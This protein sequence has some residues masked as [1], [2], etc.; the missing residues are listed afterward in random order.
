MKQKDWKKLISTLPKG[1]TARDAARTLGKKYSTVLMWLNKLGYK[2]R[3]GRADAW[4]LQRRLSKTKINPKKINWS[5]PNIEIARNLGV[6][7]ERIRQLR[8]S[9]RK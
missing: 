1:L 5:L 2:Y 9:L 8:N 4:P 6:S 7:R 3:D